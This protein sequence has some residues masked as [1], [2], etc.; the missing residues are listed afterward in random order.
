MNRQFVKKMVQAKRLEYQALKEIMPEKLA[1]RVAKLE[2][3]LLEFGKELVMTALSDLPKDEQTSGSE[4]K[5][6][7]RRVTIE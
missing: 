1:K 4:A 2:G 5:P 7:T 3:E 6:R